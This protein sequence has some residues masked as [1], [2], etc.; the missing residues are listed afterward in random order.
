MFPYG[1]SGYLSPPSLIQGSCGLIFLFRRASWGEQ[2]DPAEFAVLDLLGPASVPGTAAQDLLWCSDWTAGSITSWAWEW[3]GHNSLCGFVFSQTDHEN[4]PPLSPLLVSA[5]L[6]LTLI[7]TFRFTDAF[8]PCTLSTL[9]P[10]QATPFPISNL[11]DT[12]KLDKSKAAIHLIIGRKRRPKTR[13]PM[14]IFFCAFSIGGK[15]W[16]FFSCR[17][18]GKALKCNG[19]LWNFLKDTWESLWELCWHFGISIEANKHW[20]IHAS[21]LQSG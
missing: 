14:S 7:L 5:V 9:T 8:I 21:E 20:E 11:D 15:P 19:K 6:F 18:W 17:S 4:S 3:E 13:C 2:S 12:R 10:T 1:S 16:F